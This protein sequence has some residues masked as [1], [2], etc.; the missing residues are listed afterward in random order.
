MSAVTQTLHCCGE[1]RTVCKSKAVD[2]P[3]D[4]CFHLHLWSQALGSD[5]NNRIAE[6]SDGNEVPQQ[7]AGLYLRDR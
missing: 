3:V 2:L 1:A 7:S 6:T 5:Q 4:L